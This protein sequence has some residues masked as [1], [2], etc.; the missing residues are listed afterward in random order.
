MYTSIRMKISAFLCLLIAMLV[1]RPA[2]AQF[3]IVG[4]WS[5]LIHEDQPERGPGPELGDYLGLPINDGARMHAD[6]WDASRLDLREHQCKVHTV[7]YIYRGPLQTR[8]WEEKDPY[9]QQ[10]VAIKGYVSTYEQPRTIWMDGRPHPPEYEKHTWQGFSTGKFDGD[11]LTIYTTHL[12]SEWTRRNGIPNS[13]FT[14]MVEHWVRHGNLATI[15]TVV[16]DPVY[17]SEP[18][19]KSTD[20]RL[21]E[22]PAG[23]WLWPCEYVDEVAGLKQGYVPH[24]LPGKSPFQGE[25]AQ[26]YGI[27]VEATRGGAETMFPEYLS[28]MKTAA[29]TPAAKTAAK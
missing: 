29:A 3:S 11:S 10:L 13:E 2:H 24:Y 9:T 1:S 15:V 27:P 18:L 17:L 8:F 19:V 25:F 7:N 20:F 14:T 21:N 5:P 6:S 22:R 26:K 12:K 23:G 16:T 4:D 28:K